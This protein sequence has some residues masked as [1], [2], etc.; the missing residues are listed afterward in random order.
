M[1]GQAHGNQA[2]TVVESTVGNFL[3]PF[4]TPL[5]FK[6]YLAN[7]AWYTKVLPREPGGY[8]ALYQR[9]FKQLGLSVFIPMV[10]QLFQISSQLHTDKAQIAGQ[11]VQNVFPGPTKTVCTKYKASKLGSM[12]LL[13]IIW[14]T[15]DQA[16]SSNALQELPASN[17]A[18]IVFMSIAL[19]SLLLAVSL[20]TSKLWMGRADTVAMCYCIPAKT[21]A[22]GV[23]MSTVLFIGL[24]PALEARLQL[25]LVIYQGLQIIA[26]TVLTGP[27]KKWVDSEKKEEAEANS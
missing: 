19:F 2:L 26:G 14:Q 9:V 22:M 6:A 1:T 12:A 21:P 4:L 20:V 24:S 17:I 5:L 25:P 10:T 13:I 23:P 27:F 16:F 7:G 15:Y 18:F 3:G 11:I 8:A